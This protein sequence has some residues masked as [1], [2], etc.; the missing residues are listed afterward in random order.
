M[1][2]RLLARLLRVGDEDVEYIYIYGT[3]GDK[4]RVEEEVQ[5]RDLECRM[6]EGD[7]MNNDGWGVVEVEG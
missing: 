6:N 1:W 4:G 5:V 2:T 3:G 7:G